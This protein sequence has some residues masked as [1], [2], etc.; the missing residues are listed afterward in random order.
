MLLFNLTFGIIINLLLLFNCLLK[1]DIYWLCFI[2]ISIIYY[3]LD[4]CLEAFKYERYMYIPH[5]ILSTI[6]CI[7]FFFIGNINNASMIIL[8]I[9][10]TTLILNIREILKNKKKLSLTADFMFLIYY[11]LIRC[12]IAPY[13]SCSFRSNKIIYFSAN[14][15]FLMSII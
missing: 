2:I 10:S 5:H 11:A 8:L 13:F 7:C 4:T 9:E 12:F 14:L 1:K 15:I 6:I 3:I